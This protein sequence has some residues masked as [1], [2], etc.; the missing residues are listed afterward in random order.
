MLLARP[1]RP[2]LRPFVQT[3]WASDGRDDGGHAQRELVLPTGAMH[4]VFR[5]DRALRLYADP[6]DP[7]GRMIGHSIVGGARSGF[8]LRD[9][10]QPSRSVGA[11]LQPAAA[12][13]LLG[14]PA[15]ELA[16]RHTPLEELWGAEAER[17]RAQLAAADRLEG[18]VSAQG[19]AATDRS[20]PI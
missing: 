2:A 5:L 19:A 8:Y 6:H 4:V 11:Q 3:L 10:S 7:V 13:P 14:V 15:G 16:E 9:V 12:G 20:G 1:P 17:I 18:S